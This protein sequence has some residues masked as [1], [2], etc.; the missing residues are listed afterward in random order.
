MQMLSRRAFSQ[1]GAIALVGCA[2][3]QGL[4]SADGRLKARPGIVAA[5]TGRRGVFKL[6]AWPHSLAYVPEGLDASKPAPLVLLLHG[7]GQQADRILDRMMPA[8]KERGVVILAPQA[9]RATWDIIRAGGRGGEP[10]FGADPDRIDA[11]LGA[12]FQQ[13]T[14]DPAHIAIAGFSDG[15]TYALSLGPRNPALFTHIMAFSPGGVASFSDAAHARVFVSHGR[16]DSILPFANSTD[17]I[18]PGF[19]ERGF[20]VRF[21]PFDGDHVFREDEID[22]ALDW[23]LG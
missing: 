19:K 8:A 9:E 4:V 6:E 2:G 20:D 13:V 11:S 12:L 18:V 10:R 3:E 21:E 7:A 15:A 17:R 22:N 1:L 16:K 14:I 23:L 5:P